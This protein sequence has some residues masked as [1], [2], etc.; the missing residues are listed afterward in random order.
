[1]AKEGIFGGPGKADAYAKQAGRPGFVENNPDFAPIPPPEDIGTSITTLL[2][3]GVIFSQQARKKLYD[4]SDVVRG[5]SLADFWENTRWPRDSSVSSDVRFGL[6]VTGVDDIE[7]DDPMLAEAPSRSFERIAVRKLLQNDDDDDNAE[8][9]QLEQNNPHV[10]QINGVS[11][12]QSNI[13]D[14]EKDCI[15]FLSAKFC[16]TCKSLNQK[17]TRLAR[18]EKENDS[19]VFFA[20]AEMGTSWGKKLGRALEVDVVPSFVLFR[21]GKRFGSSLSVNDLPSKKIGRALE[22]L[23]SGKDW[24][25]MILKEE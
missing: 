25:P 23:E 11:G 21:K 16:K 9:P 12:M 6:P 7:E 10:Y 1:V 3:K 20:K 18:I 19:P 17:Y 22:L 8:A 24:D 2:G 13:M 14:P 15:L 4:K 5:W